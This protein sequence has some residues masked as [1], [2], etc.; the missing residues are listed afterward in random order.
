MTAPH[1]RPAGKPQQ[2]A[3]HTNTP[4]IRIR[5]HNTADNGNKKH[6]PKN[7]TAKKI[8]KNSPTTGRAQATHHTHA[9]TPPRQPPPQPA[10]GSPR[11]AMDEQTLTTG[12]DGNAIIP[13]HALCQASD[14]PLV[15]LQAV[16]AHLRGHGHV[17]ASAV[18]CTQDPSACPC[19]SIPHLI[20]HHLTPARVRTPGRPRP[21]PILFSTPGLHDCGI[22]RYCRQ[23]THEPRTR[24]IRTPYAYAYA[25]AGDGLM[26]DSCIHACGQHHDQACR[27]HDRL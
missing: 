4:T 21:P 27:L 13:Q 22:A 19:G 3:D 1:S 5:A 15:Q 9:A 8:N 7:T 6:A 25:Y 2:Q 20:R 26:Q 18:N 24:T 12:D 16:R 14:P 11:P 23:C 17:S 10:P